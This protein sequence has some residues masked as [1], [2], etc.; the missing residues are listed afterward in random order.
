MPVYNGDNGMNAM[1]N[2]ILMLIMLGFAGAEWA[3]RRYR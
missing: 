1:Q 2:V 3:S